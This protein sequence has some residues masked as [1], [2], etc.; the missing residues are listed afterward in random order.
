MCGT[1]VARKPDRTRAERLGADGIATAS[2]R[3]KP[4]KSE[5][6]RVRCLGG[7]ERQGLRHNGPKRGVPERHP[8]ATRRGHGAAQRASA[9]GPSGTRGRPAA[10]RRRWARRTFLSP[11]CTH[12]APDNFPSTIG[13]TLCEHR[14]NPGSSGN[15]HA[16]RRCAS[17]SVAMGARAGAT[18]TKRRVCS[19]TNLAIAMRAPTTPPRSPRRPQKRGRVPANSSGSTTEP[20][21]APRDGA[22]PVKGIIAQHPNAETHGLQHKRVAPKTRAKHRGGTPRQRA[23]VV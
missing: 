1:R 16:T 18:I 8:C 23:S 7:A 22:P 14:H 2:R 9:R 15:T 10:R 19:S 3:P 17:A 21:D 5:Y 4:V 13:Q 20:F 12:S 6:I 11:P